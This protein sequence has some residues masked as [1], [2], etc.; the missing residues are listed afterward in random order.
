MIPLAPRA[1]GFY[2]VQLGAGWKTQGAWVVA[3]REARGWQVID[4]PRYY[5]DHEFDQIKPERLRSPAE[6]V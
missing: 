5:G 1:D 2:W 6:P 4:E 3:E